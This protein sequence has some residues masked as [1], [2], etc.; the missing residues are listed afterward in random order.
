M[1]IKTTKEELEKLTL[2][3]SE[4]EVIDYGGMFVNPKYLGNKLQLQM[5]Q[6]LD[7]YAKSLGYKYA[8]A[9]VH[10]DNFYSYNNFLEDNFSY[11]CFV[12]LKRGPRNIYIKE[13]NTNYNY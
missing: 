6:V 11:Q 2:P 9:T 12:E 3:F 4:N 7:K 8:I 13:L 5:L 1:I 10:P